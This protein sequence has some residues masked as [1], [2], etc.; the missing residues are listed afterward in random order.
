MLLSL[1]SLIGFFIYGIM[2]MYIAH[3]ARVIPGMVGFR[4][5]ISSMSVVVRGVL[6]IALIAVLYSVYSKNKK[7]S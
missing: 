7:A 5:D 3:G 6:I 4:A 2:K 1:F